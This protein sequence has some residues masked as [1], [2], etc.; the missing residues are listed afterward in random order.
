MAPCL[1]AIP[2]FAEFCLPH[3]IEKLSS[4]RKVAKLD[5][6]NLLIKGAETFGA[7]G[8]KNHAGLFYN[9]LK[10][11]VTSGSD[12]EI[13]N[14]ALNAITA[15]VRALAGDEKFRHDFIADNLNDLNWSM[16]D[17]TKSRYWPAEKILEAM[18][19][20]DKNSCIQILREIVPLSIGQYTTK[21]STGDKVRLMETLNN[22]MKI[23]G[24]FGFTISGK[25]I[26]FF[27]SKVFI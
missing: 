11:E 14:A 9:I 21:T 5:S 1:Y 16:V 24:N 6:L 3:I 27:S 8:L 17:M 10:K 23:S 12:A 20:A 19:R 2:Q 26:F 22:F 25:L 4:D 7:Q 18:A 15:V 13:K